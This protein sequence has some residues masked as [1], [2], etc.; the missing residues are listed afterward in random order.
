MQR[1]RFVAVCAS[2]VVFISA[3]TAYAQETSKASASDLQA[4]ID[5]HN[6]EINQLNQE[7]AQYQVQLD[8]T[9][10]KKQ[11]L[12]NTLSQI[13][14]SI[15]KTTTSIKV[16]QNKIGAT[17][18]QI[19]QL[20]GN[21]ATVQDQIAHSE[22]GLAESLRR[23]HENETEPLV[24]QMIS[25][26]N[27]SEMWEDVDQTFALDAAVIDNVE[28]LSGHKQQLADTKSSVETQQ[29]QLVTQQKTL[30]SQ[31][32]SLSA[33]KLSQ[34]ELLSQTKA[35]EANYQAIIKQKKAQQQS[36]ENALADLKSKLNVVVNPSQITPAGKGVLSWPLD[37]VIITQFFGNTAFAASG[38]YNGKGHN[39][40]DFGAS[41]GTPVHAALAGTVAGTGNTDAVRGCYSFGKWI[42]IKHPNGLDTIYAHLS[43]INVSTGQAVSTGDVIG[44]SGETGYATGPHLHFGVYV[45][46][47]T[48]IMR[49]GDA[50]QK[51]TPCA[52]ATMPVAPLAGYLNPMN[53]LPSSGYSSL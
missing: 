40:I 24:L 43:Q 49:L 35:Q 21:I 29:N 32:G 11:T 14:L 30:V 17:Q 39:G 12:Q 51:S 45:A 44:Y 25:S 9:S 38:A 15:K 52:G 42:L 26:N 28:I 18:L 47:A 33:T 5:Q 1:I 22:A 13:N 16:T 20:S 23:L 7:I 48:Q 2:L 10:K 41:I 8:A 31:Q 50:T 3:S 36:F 4:Q 6:Q 19:Q 53:Y 34:S 27:A 37:K 46:S